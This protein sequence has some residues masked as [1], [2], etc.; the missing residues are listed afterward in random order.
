M[1]QEIEDDE[2]VM[3]HNIEV[4]RAS[5]ARRAALSSAAKWS[6]RMT[7]PRCPDYENM[8]SLRDLFI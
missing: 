3:G 2:V 4:V 1:V 7:S 6:V 5:G 8:S